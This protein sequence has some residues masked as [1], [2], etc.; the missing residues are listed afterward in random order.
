MWQL[1]SPRH[2]ERGDVPGWV[3]ITVMSAGLVAVLVGCRRTAAAPDADAGAVGGRRLSHAVLGRAAHERG[4][5]VVDFVL[6]MVLLVPLVLGVAQVALV[7]H[8]RNTAAAAASEGA[9][10]SAPLGATPADGAARTR[11][12]IRDAL[13]RS[14]CR[15]RHR[16]PH[17][18][19]RR[20]RHRGR[21]TCAGPGARDCS[22]RPCRS[23]CEV[24][25]SATWSHEA[26][27]RHRDDRV[28]LALDP[29]ARALRLHPRRGV[30]RP[31]SVLRCL[32]GE[33]FG[34]TSVP[35]GARR[36]GGGAARAACGTGRPGRPRARR[37]RASASPACRRRRTVS[38]PV[39][40]S[41]SSSVRRRRCRSPRAHSGP[42]SA[43]SRSTA[44]TPS[45]TERSGAS[46][47]A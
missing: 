38:N 13:G 45:P 29:A 37:R 22:A 33:P 2:D 46:D 4:A 3:M 18:G 6:I 39:R 27:G 44:P 42:S 19:R 5:A 28:R 12:M 43:A 23:P 16:D 36:R 34:S 8:V 26:R 7:L 17:H 31:T 14:L 11:S 1:R 20:S 35:P 41:G 24:T 32:D 15:R 30:R 9:R 47:E 10:A 40:R 21:R 25:P